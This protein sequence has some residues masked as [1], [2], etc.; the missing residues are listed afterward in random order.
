MS[1]ETPTQKK[2]KV[3]GAVPSSDSNESLSK[4]S[5]VPSVPLEIL[6][7]IFHNL[8]YDQ[9]IR[10]CRLVCKQWREVSDSESLWRERCRRERLLPRDVTRTPD[11]WREYYVL[12]RKR[13]NLLKNPRAEH[14]FRYWQIVSNGGD[15]WTIEDPKVPHPNEKVQKNFVT[16]F[17]MCLKSQDIDL[18]REGY[19]ASF[20]DWYQPPIRISDW[21]AARHDCACEYK[22]K[23]E[24]LNEKKKCLQ[25]FEPEMIRF[26][27]W[28][29][30]QWHQMSHIFTNYGPGVRYVRFV[31]GG[32]DGQYWKGWYGVR[33]TDSCVEVCPEVE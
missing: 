13:R 16:S 7:E 21:Y 28:S 24:L 1:V 8:P 9:V 25:K 27:Q 11:D 30:Q 19:N 20:M 17:E 4:E 3:M 12:C 22:I 31:H 18:K 33:V 6:E 29:N 26:E 10:R 23:V 2:R 14:N 5:P 15:H 32:K